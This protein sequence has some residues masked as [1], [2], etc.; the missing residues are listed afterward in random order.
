MGWTFQH[1]D[2]GVPDLEWWRRE[3][4]AE[5]VIDSAS[6]LG[7]SFLAW[8]TEDDKVVA[9]VCLTRWV[10]EQ[11][12]YGYKEMDEG[13]GPGEDRCP[14]RIF[15]MLSPLDEVYDP[16]SSSHQWAS[17]WRVKVQA[18]LDARKARPKV[19]KGSVVRFKEPLP[20]TDGS[21]H[22]TFVYE[23][24]TSFRGEHGYGRYR[25]SNW[26]S[27]PYEVVQQ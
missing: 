1:R 19:K 3:F 20:F 6:V 25:I 14:E 11:Y 26:R 16:G 22:D 17:E 8:R 13:M 12:N 23:A 21:T 9:V 4:G 7:A 10:N 24:N 5:R 27:R 15:K 2:R 18:R